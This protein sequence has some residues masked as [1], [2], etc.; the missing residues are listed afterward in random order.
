MIK[1]FTWKKNKVEKKSLGLIF[2]PIY[3]VYSFW[4]LVRKPVNRLAMQE[5]QVS[6]SERS[7]GEGSGYLLQCS[8]LW[9]IPWT[10]DPG[11]AAVH[12]VTK[13]RTQLTNMSLHS[14]YRIESLL[15]LSKIAK[16][17]LKENWESGIKRFDQA[18]KISKLKWCSGSQ[19]LYFSK[20][21]YFL[22]L[23]LF[24]TEV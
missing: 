6:G 14:V 15:W 10:G 20:I 22:V 5:T 19:V 23:I 1:I 24:L 16:I 9:R 17:S 7:A 13:S 4:W 3:P 11:V 18:E 21:E 8:C 2:V 12:G